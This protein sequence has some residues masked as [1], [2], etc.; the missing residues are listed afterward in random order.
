MTPQQKYID[1]LSDEILAL[2]NEALDLDYSDLTARATAI[3][4][5]AWRE[6]RACD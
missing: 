5:K 3:A 6:A 4:M 2:V 1:S